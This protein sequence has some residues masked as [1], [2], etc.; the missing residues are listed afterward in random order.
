MRTKLMPALII[1]LA[2]VVATVTTVL[3]DTS[4]TR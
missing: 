2:G 1:A 4:W 3:A